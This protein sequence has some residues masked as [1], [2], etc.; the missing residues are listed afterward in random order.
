[1]GDRKVCV[2]GAGYWGKNHIR[3]LYELDSLGGIVENNTALLQDISKS[4]PNVE[5]YPSLEDALKNDDFSGFTVAT[6]AETHFELSKEL[7][8][9]IVEYAKNKKI[10]IFSAPSHIKDLEIMK[11]MDLDIYKIGSDLAC[12]VPLLKKV[13]K[14]GKPIIL[15]TGMSTL[16]EI[17]DALAI[18][19]FGFVNGNSSKI[20]PSRKDFQ[21][22][23]LLEEGKR[24]LKERVTLLHC[25]TEYPA[26]MNEIN[27]NAMLTM[28]N[29]FG[30]KVGYSD[31]SEGISV[32]TAAT[33]LGA[34]LIEKHFTL[35]K[36]LPGPDHK[37]SL[38]PSEFN[39]RTFY[40]NLL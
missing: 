9:Q 39:Q 35:N 37:A 11:E 38:L 36:S 7:Q 10:P 34:T 33:A 15:S 16:A 28:S 30:L 17:E 22:A 32:S 3:T 24:L 29:V 23:F 13:A 2:V 1:M 4:Y 19:A 31:H 12:H 20:D 5:S 21:E 14:L 6:P 8:K 18:L 26:P 40:R 27:L 25:T